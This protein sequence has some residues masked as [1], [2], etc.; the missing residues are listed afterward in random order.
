M[1]LTIDRKKTWLMREHRD[2]T[3]VYTWMNDERCMILIPTYRQK[4]PWYVVMESASYTWDDEDP[5]N[6]PLVAAKAA[7]CCEVLGMEPTPANCN[8]VAAIIIDGLPDLIRMPSSPPVEQYKTGF[9]K[10]ELRAGGETIAQEVIR[11]DK[12]DG[13]SYG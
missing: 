4:A 9:G 5:A 13:A 1:A 8:R 11:L 12:E 2:L 7:K 3:A 6:V 10:M